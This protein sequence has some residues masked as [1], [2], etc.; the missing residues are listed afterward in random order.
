LPTLARSVTQSLLQSPEK[1]ATTIKDML[2][3]QYVPFSLIA[4]FQQFDAIIV[5]A[6]PVL[7]SGF[8]VFIFH[9]AGTWPLL[10]CYAH[11]CNGLK[12]LWRKYILRWLFFLAARNS[13]VS[14]VHITPFVIRFSVTMICAQR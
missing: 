2:P 11:C 10:S 3:S 4:L 12:G 5:Q 6:F 8:L 1:F 13:S 9:V 14:F 7:S